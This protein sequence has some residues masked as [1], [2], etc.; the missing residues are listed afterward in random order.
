MRLTMNINYYEA[1][2][3]RSAKSCETQEIDGP[4]LNLLHWTLG[5][6]GEVGEVVDTVKK[7]VYYNQPLDVD[8]L[9]EELGDSLYFI[10]AMAQEIGTT[11]TELMIRNHNKLAVRYPDGYSDEDAKNRFDKQVDDFDQK[12]SYIEGN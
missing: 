3:R 8:N 2:V 4:T 1:S 7:H 11:T 5:L 6:S 10:T 12:G 9:K